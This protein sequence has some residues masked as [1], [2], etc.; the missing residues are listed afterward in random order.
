MKRKGYEKRQPHHPM[1]LCSVASNL[2]SIFLSEV[3]KN[4]VLMSV[5][6]GFI[7]C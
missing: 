7:P 3:L 5:D 1:S 2:Y 6:G 4:S